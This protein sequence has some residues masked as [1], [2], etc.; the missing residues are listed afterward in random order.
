MVVLFGL[1][2]TAFPYKAD[3]INSFSLTRLFE[4]QFSYTLTVTAL[5][6]MACTVL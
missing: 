1:G 4:T 3:S 5:R 6:L 2:Y